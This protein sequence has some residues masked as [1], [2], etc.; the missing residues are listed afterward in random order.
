MSSVI[1]RTIQ[2]NFRH[3]VYFTKRVFDPANPL[4]KTVLQNNENRDIHKALAVV[5]EALAAA[6][7]RLSQ[8]IEAYFAAFLN[9]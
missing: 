6:Q 5:D 4:L 9:A 1:E 2:V 8:C 7:P 3:Q